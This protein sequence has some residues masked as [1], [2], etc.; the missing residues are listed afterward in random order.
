MESSEPL[1]KVGKAALSRWKLESLTGLLGIRSL[2]HHQA[3]T[4]KNIRA[5]NQCVRRKLWG[6]ES[7]QTGDSEGDMGHTVLGDYHSPTP[8]VISGQQSSGS[9]FAKVLAGLAI[10]TLIPT[11]GIGGFA[12]SKILQGPTPK[13]E[14]QPGHSKEF[15]D[16]SLDIGLLR[17]EDLKQPTPSE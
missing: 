5:E 14:T 7:E 16:E 12:I 3:E 9:G 11:A 8:I 15:T 2:Q 10:G 1:K 6:D 17:F 4:E 13:A